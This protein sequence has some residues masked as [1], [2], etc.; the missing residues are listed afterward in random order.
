M[1]LWWCTWPGSLRFATNPITARIHPGSVIDT[2]TEAIGM[3]LFEA[4]SM[5][6]NNDLLLRSVTVVTDTIVASSR[7]LSPAV[8]AD[9]RAMVHV[10]Y[11]EVLPFNT[12]RERTS[13]QD[14][15]KDVKT[16]HPLFM[17]KPVESDAGGGSV[18]AQV[19]KCS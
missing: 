17:I 8:L 3:V 15:I 18:G 12:K 7:A 13:C 2:K 16:K 5:A 9:V 14:N 19:S 11:S 10:R 1:Y 6:A 4:R